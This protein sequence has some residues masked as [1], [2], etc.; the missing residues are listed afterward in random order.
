MRCKVGSVYR[1]LDLYGWAQ[2]S[3]T[4]VTVKE[5]SWL[6]PGLVAGSGLKPD[7]F[8]HPAF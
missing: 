4:F 8:N 5:L 3:S 6:R 7:L 2:L 1:L